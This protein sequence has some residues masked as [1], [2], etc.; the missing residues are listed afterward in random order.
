MKR[1]VYLYDAYFNEKDGVSVIGLMTPHGIFSGSAKLNSDEDEWNE[2]TGGSLAELRA[3]KNYYKY[4][5][6][7]R[8]FTKDYLNMIYSQAKKN[9][10]SELLKDH[11]DTLDAEIEGCKKEILD[12]D[13]EIAMRI[14]RLGQK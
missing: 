9:H 6:R 10:F 3:W 5:K 1:K 8:T 13:N 2:I 4:E 14:E 11:I 7:I 12:I